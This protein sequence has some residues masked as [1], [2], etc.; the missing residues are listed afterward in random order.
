[1]HTSTFVHTLQVFSMTFNAFLEF[2]RNCHIIGPHC[3]G[4]S[5]EFIWV[6]VNAMQLNKEL[7]H[8]DRFNHA[9]R[10]VH[11]ANKRTPSTAFHTTSTHRLPHH[12]NCCLMHRL[13]S[14]TTPLHS[15]L[16]Y[17][18]TKPFPCP[19][20]QQVRH[21]FIQAL[22]R[23]AIVTYIVPGRERSVAVASSFLCSKHT[24][25]VIVRAP[26]SPF[27]LCLNMRRLPPL[28]GGCFSAPRH[29]QEEC[30]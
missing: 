8:I 19:A 9:R 21:E 22:V 18:P 3:S 12:L 26:V 28:P 25:I 23:I 20:V 30:A 4:S 15:C 29:A 10:M 6:Q 13:K 27:H 7:V 16:S 17:L 2:A 1:M 14:C 24:Y 11:A 5:I